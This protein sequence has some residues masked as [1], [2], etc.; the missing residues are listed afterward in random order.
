MPAEAKEPFQE[1][2]IFTKLILGVSSSSFL[3][4]KRVQGPGRNYCKKASPK[5][6]DGLRLLSRLTGY[7]PK[8][9]VVY[10]RIENVYGNLEGTD[11]RK[12][13]RRSKTIKEMNKSFA[14]LSNHL[15][16]CKEKS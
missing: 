15:I 16:H 12:R 14:F 7:F 8:A 6:S 10:S 11:R 3:S 5:L 13:A 9:T 4:L 2:W 1:S